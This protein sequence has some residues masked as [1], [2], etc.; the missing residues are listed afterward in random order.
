MSLSEQMMKEWLKHREALQR[1]L[2]AI[3][4]GQIGYK[5]WSGAMGLGELALHIAA[6]TDMFVS[7]AKSGEG[8]ITMP[9]VEECH[10]MADVRRAVQSFTEQ[11]KDT[12]AS[13]TDEEL[14]KEYAS[15][16]PNLHGPR[17]KLVKLAIDHEI[18]HKGQL[19]LYA[20]MVGAEQLPFFI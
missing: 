7:T 17:K 6:S 4:D 10:T 19:F 9:S 3:P 14:E 11:T 20:R 1:L 8:K 15:P 13:M 16:H 2:D 18:H 5:P 12:F